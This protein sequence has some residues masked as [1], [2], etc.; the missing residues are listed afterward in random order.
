VHVSFDV[1]ISTVQVNDP[2]CSATSRSITREEQD[3]INKTRKSV[4]YFITS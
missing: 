2:V 1:T 3:K 4:R